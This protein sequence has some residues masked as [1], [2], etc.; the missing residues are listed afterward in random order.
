MSFKE[1]IKHLFIPSHR[2]NFKARLLHLDSL[3]LFIVMACLLL[4]FQTAAKHSILGIATDIQLDRLFQLTNEQRAAQGLSPLTLS[5]VL[6]DAAR[7]KAAYMFEKDYW[8]HT[9]PDG[10]S[11]WAF[12]NQ[13]GYSYELAGEN[14]AKDFNDSGGVIQGLM[15][16]PTHRANILRPDYTEIGFAVV[17]GK[18]QGEETT[19]VVQL[20]GR[21]ARA[22]AKTSTKTQ[23]AEPVQNTLLPTPTPTVASQKIQTGTVM[24]KAVGE[25]SG[26]STKATI[27]SYI[28]TAIS[29][30]TYITIFILALAV[31]LDIYYAYRLNLFRLSGKNVAHFMVLMVAIITFILFTKGAIL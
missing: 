27:G 15:N 10:T 23:A 17:N 11:P 31:V 18:L 28:S 16:S 12:F 13:A 29:D 26:I 14:L 30:T 7:R 9:A 21:P 2:N 24:N 6:S 5:P 19:L 3:S 25:L 1:S 22:I 8:A 4:T 20:F